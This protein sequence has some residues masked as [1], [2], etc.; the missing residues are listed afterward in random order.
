MG[1]NELVARAILREFFIIKQQFLRMEQDGTSINR[2]A[3]YFIHGSSSRFRAAAIDTRR[4]KY[5][6]RKSATISSLLKFK[7]EIIVKIVMCNFL[8]ANNI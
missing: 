2:V 4:Q 6:I 1:L 8:E 5:H 7:K 3:V